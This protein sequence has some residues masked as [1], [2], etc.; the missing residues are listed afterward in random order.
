MKKRLLAL[1]L[2]LVLAV[3]L[4]PITAAAEEFTVN[5]VCVVGDF[6]NWAFSESYPMQALGSGVYELTIHN[7]SRWD[8]DGRKEKF[9]INNEW[10]HFFGG[11]FV[12]SGVAA[13][14]EY[15]GGD[16]IFSVPYDSAD[17]TFR[18]DLSKFDFS[19]KQGATFT[20]TITDANHNF[21]T[22][23]T[24]DES[25]HWHKCLDEGCTATSGK[26]PH[27]DNNK[28]HLCDDCKASVHTW[29]YEVSRAGDS[30]T[31]T[32]NPGCTIG[33]VTVKLNAHSVTLPDSP[34]NATLQFEGGVQ[35]GIPL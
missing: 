21:D 16:L 26:A 9:A 28:D 33:E 15:N 22:G 6:C 13:D 29:S 25:S 11:T 10:T 35:G 4:L 20:I 12:G 24:S 34:F 17:I 32:C 19:T 18:L 23:W 14:A 27:F 7:A 5:S 8:F 31:A 3:S 2:C 30:L 1:A